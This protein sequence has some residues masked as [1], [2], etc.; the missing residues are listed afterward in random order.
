MA[1]DW[2]Y[3]GTAGRALS[4]DIRFALTVAREVHGATWIVEEL[5]KAG[6]MLKLAADG[7]GP[8]RSR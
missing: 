7:P 5:L 1:G 6:A 4:T 2:V 3:D 8:T